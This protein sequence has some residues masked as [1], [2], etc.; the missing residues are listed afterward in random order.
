MTAVKAAPLASSAS[1]KKRPAVGLKSKGAEVV[2][3]DKFAHH[4]F[5]DGLRI[6]AARCKR[7]VIEA[8]FHRGQLVEL[9]QI[10]LE[11]EIRLCRKQGVVALIVVAGV[12][13]A[14]VGIADADQGLRD[15]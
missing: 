14:I 10:L 2:A 7:P 11:Q 12:D 15:P 6:F 3:R 8:R 4:R 1:V 5:G 13:A 9:R